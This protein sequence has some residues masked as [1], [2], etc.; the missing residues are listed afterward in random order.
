MK[1][2]TWQIK[3]LLKTQLSRDPEKTLQTIEREQICFNVL[4][5]FIFDLIVDF[6]YYSLS[7]S[8]HK[9]PKFPKPYLFLMKKII[10]IINIIYYILPVSFDDVFLF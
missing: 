9:F 6:Y 2:A 7:L 10:I 1:V 8:C 4:S 5:L 3:T